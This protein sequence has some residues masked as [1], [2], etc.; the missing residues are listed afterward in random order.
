M[1]VKQTFGNPLHN[2]RELMTEISDY[3]VYVY[4]DPRN[5]EEFY[6]GKGRGNRKYS[7]LHNTDDEKGKRIQEIKQSGLEPIIKVI[8]AN[9][10]EN[11]AFLI[12]TTLIW[13]LGRLLTNKVAGQFSEKFR[14]PNS[15]Y[16]DLY[17]FDFQNGVYY[18]NVGEGEHRCWADCK[19]WG[20]LS[21]GQGKQWNEQ[22]KT[23][24]VGDVVVAYLKR[25]KNIGGYVGIGIVREPAVMAQYFRI[26]GKSLDQL[27]LLQ[28]RILENAKD[29]DKAEYP[30]RVSWAVSVNAEEGKWVSNQKLF[31][32]QLIKASL[33]NQPETIKFLEAE[34]GINPYNL[35]KQE[36]C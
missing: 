26:D 24:Q 3:Y 4:I 11:E 29:A 33:Q 31:T 32:T 35:L 9:L 22:I 13:K 27:N 34:F 25:K 20:F 5:Y 12:E 15:L 1:Q 36:G 23:L 30:V 17:G 14:K 6:Y 16:L 2:T 7:H 19:K 21:A 10:S 18:V 28:P 8:A